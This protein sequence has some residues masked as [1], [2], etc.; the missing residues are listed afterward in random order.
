MFAHERTQTADLRAP[1]MCTPGALPF[2]LTAARVSVGLGGG[3]CWVLGGCV[4]VI[5]VTRRPEVSNTWSLF[6]A[7]VNHLKWTLGTKVGFSAAYS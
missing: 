7:V 4:R 2:R 3:A 6:Q 1:V 5:V